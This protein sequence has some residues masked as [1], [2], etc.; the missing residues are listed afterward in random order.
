MATLNN[1]SVTLE[2]KLSKS[3]SIL[4]NPSKVLQ[5]KSAT[6]EIFHKISR[7]ADVFPQIA[8]YRSSLY[9]LRPI[10]KAE[11][12]SVTEFFTR[13]LSRF[14]L[15]R[16]IASAASARDYGMAVME[17]TE[18]IEMD[19]YTV[20][21]RVELCPPEYYFF[22]KSRRLRLS[23]DTNR[24]GIDVF[25]TWQGKFILVQN[26]DTLTNPYGVGL[27]DIAFWLAVGLNGNF[28]FLMQFCEEDGRDRWIGYYQPGSTDEQISE[29][30]N[31]LVQGRNNSVAALPDG[32][33]VELKEASG[34]SSSKDL[35]V[36]ADEMLRRKIEKLWTGTDL[37]MQVDGKGGYSSSSNG[38]TIREEALEEGVAL[39][40]SALRQ[41][42]EI[43]SYLNDMP[44]VPQVTLQMP[45]S[46]SKTIAETDKLY[47]DMGMR[48]TKELL[49][50]RGYAEE[51]FILERPSQQTTTADFAALPSDFVPLVGVFEDYCNRIKK[52]EL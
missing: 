12:D 14:D 45:K 34:R 51:D 13:Y 41:L 40:V 49:I 42:C 25:D 15:R 44:E 4:P 3:L 21:S 38:L 46:L 10:I 28:E 9:S 2:Q 16:L 5:S 37:T 23:S 6:M 20:P 36:G 7:Q 48:P 32:M 18:Y 31:M 33:R 24:E 27:L 1:N 43:V 11:N 47:Y 35:Y 22:D 30:L 52:K 39:A 8:S 50:K 19:G 17:I 26:N 29:L